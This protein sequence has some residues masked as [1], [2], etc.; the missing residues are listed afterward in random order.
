MCQGGDI[1]FLITKMCQNSIDDVLIL[2]APVRRPDDDP[3]GT[4]TTA[5]N[6]NVDAEYSLG[7]DIGDEADYKLL[8]GFLEV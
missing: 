2:D 3:N 8:G 7:R 4:T 5:A 6:L 1:P